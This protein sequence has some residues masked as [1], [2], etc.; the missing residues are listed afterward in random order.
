MQ[1]NYLGLHH[2]QTLLGRDGPFS[3]GVKHNWVLALVEITPQRRRC[4]WQGLEVSRLR[5]PGE[6]NPGQSSEYIMVSNHFSSSQKNWFIR[7]QD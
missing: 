2:T 5:L 4:D 6:S 1:D 7:D 3:V